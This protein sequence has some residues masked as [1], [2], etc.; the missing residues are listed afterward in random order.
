MSSDENMSSNEEQNYSSDPSTE[1][2]MSYSDQEPENSSS[3]SENPSSNYSEDEAMCSEPPPEPNMSMADGSQA[4]VTPDGTAL[5]YYDYTESSN[6]SSANMSYDP[7]DNYY[8][9]LCSSEPHDATQYPMS[10]Y[11][12]DYPVNPHVVLD[13]EGNEILSSLSPPTL[14]VIAV[15]SDGG[16][17]NDQLNV[18]PRKTG[19]IYWST[20]NATNIQI[21]G[22]DVEFEGSMSVPYSIADSSSFVPYELVAWNETL[23]NSTTQLVKANMLEETFI[24]F[25]M[26]DNG[27]V[28]TTPE[29]D[30]SYIDK[31]VDSVG[32]GIL[33]GGILLNIPGVA[34]PILIPYDMM[35]GGEG[36]KDTQIHS[37]HSL[38]IKA[39]ESQGL[40]C[41]YF[42]TV[43]GL[44][45]PT[46]FT[47][48]TTPR[49]MSMANAARKQL[50]EEAAELFRMEAFGLIGGKA[51]QIVLGRVFRWST[52]G[53][54]KPKV[55][56]PDIPDNN[57]TPKSTIKSSESDVY[58]GRASNKDF[59]KGLEDRLNDAIDKNPNHPLKFLLKGKTST[60]KGTLI[61][62]RRKAPSE[63]YLMSLADQPA[64]IEAGHVVSQKAG[65]DRTVIQS[66]F[67]NQLDS[68]TIEAPRKGGYVDSGTEILEIEGF[69]VEGRTARAWGEDGLLPKPTVDNARRIEIDN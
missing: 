64:Y 67:Y 32:Y 62:R 35:Q 43:N 60:K 29:Q 36:K 5:A 41:S 30:S 34:K 21:N 48:S 11:I 18:E 51:F 56:L 24:F 3:T 25:D 46:V 50:A 57:P 44:I 59:R 26:D 1:N 14:D 8:A 69:A 39:L 31:N 22:E 42:I 40:A 6:Q 63:D 7:T 16:Q 4:Y 20:Q 47:D 10:S 49:I 66:G 27:I 15:G 53:R 17:S 61:T 37:S 13:Y 65:G 2:N 33:V 38:A 58:L 9:G 55:P 45:A 19:R 68:H 23:D 28:S 52:H 12:T 54:S